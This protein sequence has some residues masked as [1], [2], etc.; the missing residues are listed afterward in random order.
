MFNLSKTLIGTMVAFPLMLA[1]LFIPAQNAIAQTNCPDVL[2][3]GV[4]GTGSVGAENSITKSYVEQYRSLPGHE[5]VYLD[6]VN[7]YPGSF[8]PLGPIMYDQS[9]EMGT[10]T[11]VNTIEAKHQECPDTT[12]KVIG[13]SQGAGVAGDGLER[14]HQRGTV[15]DEQLS[16]IGISDPRTPNTGIEVVLPGLL[17]GVTM[18]DERKDMGNIHWE[19]ECYDSDP[20]C[21]FPQP[22]QEP[23]RTFTSIGD[24]FEKHGR[25]A[26]SGTAEREPGNY[27]IPG[28]PSQ[29]NGTPVPAPVPGPELPEVPMPVLPP[30]GPLPNLAPNPYVPT[31]VKNFI[32]PE[33]QAILPPEVNNFVPPPLP[34]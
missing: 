24:Y 29:I 12:F 32:P 3:I 8:W 10:Q 23:V 21:D 26:P 17:P 2:V 16:G 34:F 22:F 6:D 30:T 7:Q 15:P 1:G 4:E 33:V 13:H 28:P 31:P 5:I 20:I 27:V 11:V 18:K 14:I 25:Y 9:R 19:T